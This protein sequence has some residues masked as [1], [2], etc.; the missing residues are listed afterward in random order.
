VETEVNISWR[1]R[2]FPYKTYTNGNTGTR[3]PSLL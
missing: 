1:P 3:R 2:R